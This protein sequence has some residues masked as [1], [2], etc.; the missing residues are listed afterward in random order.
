MRIGLLASFSIAIAPAVDPK[1]R[2]GIPRGSLAELTSAQ[3]VNAPD[4]S[5]SSTVDAN[6]QLD[7]SI[8]FA[9]TEPPCG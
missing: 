7:Y 2:P 5:I 9:D 4:G 3:S 1:Q 8:H 6:V